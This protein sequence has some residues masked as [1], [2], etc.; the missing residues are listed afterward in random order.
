MPT[1]TN[2]I[3][4]AETQEP[5]HHNEYRFDPETLSLTWEEA[6][7]CAYMYLFVGDL[8]TNIAHMT[9]HAKH[10]S[11][12]LSL[13]GLRSKRQYAPL[14]EQKADVEAQVRHWFKLALNPASNPSN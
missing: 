13:P 11:A 4:G 3:A 8:P 9:K 1:D 5:A 10:Y 14:D 12:T 7:R 2:T 6:E